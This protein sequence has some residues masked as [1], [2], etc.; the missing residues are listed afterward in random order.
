MSYQEKRTVASI[1]TG[2]VVLAAYCIY[3]FGNSRPEVTAT[4]NLKFW[5]STMLVFIGIGIGATIIVQILFHIGL[6]ISI[7]IKKT[8]LEGIKDDKEIEKTI[9]LEM[10]EDEMHK[11]VELKSTRVGF[12]IAGAGFIAALITLVMGV[13]QFVMLNILFFSFSAGSLVE[14][15]AQL[16]LYRRGV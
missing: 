1:F 12:A 11:M 16:Y 6:S 10:V 3:V 9:K 5:A 14:G 4:G 8:V 13:A 15:L 2:V 7:A